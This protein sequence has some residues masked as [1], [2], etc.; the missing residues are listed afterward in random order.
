[1]KLYKPPEAVHSIWLDIAGAALT[2]GIANLTGMLGTLIESAV[3]D[4]LVKGA[5]TRI[6]STLVEAAEI[7]AAKAQAEKSAAFVAKYTSKSIDSAMSKGAS[8]GIDHIKSGASTTDGKASSDDEHMLE[9]FRSQRSA[10]NKVNE[11]THS[12]ISASLA[13]IEP[14]LP[15]DD[16]GIVALHSAL[17]KQIDDVSERAES[18]QM[19]ASSLRYVEYLARLNNGTSKRGNT[20]TT[21][22]SGARTWLA[23]D[24]IRLLQE[25]KGILEVGILVDPSSDNVTVTSSKIHGPVS[26]VVANIIDKQELRSARLPMRFMIDPRYSNRM[27]APNVPITRDESGLV[28]YGI[29]ANPDPQALFANSAVDG[30]ALSKE[31]PDDNREAQSIATA[32]KYIEQALSKTLVEWGIATETDGSS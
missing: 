24:P 23:G 27:Y 21:D 1:M 9:F 25:V 22:M 32:E 31:R 8:A 5:T 10:I 11:E 4:A 3:K 20:E 14:S 7:E 13:K 29:V 18:E 28:R 26:K 17:S 30:P 2:I 19:N 12:S 16:T 6:S 15:Y